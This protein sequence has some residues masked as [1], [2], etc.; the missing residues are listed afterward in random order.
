M[1][2]CL[3]LPSA[4]AKSPRMELRSGTTSLARHFDAT[5]RQGRWSLLLLSLEGK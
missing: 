2:P 4:L 3:L 5:T 1:V